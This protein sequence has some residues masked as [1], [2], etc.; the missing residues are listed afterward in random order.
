MSDATPAQM[1][2][3][4]AAE[5]DRQGWQY[6]LD[7]GSALI[8]EIEKRGSVDPKAL[9][10]AV[11]AT[12]LERNR[13]TRENLAAAIARAIGD[14]TPVQRK[15]VATLVIEDHSHNVTISGNAQVHDNNFNVG[16]GTQVNV[17]VGGMRENVVAALAALLSAG[18]G[19]DWNEEAAAGLAQVIQ[20]RDD[21][22]LDDVIKTTA[23]IVKL[24]QPSAS[25]ARE[26]ME[27][28]ATA[29][30]GGAFGTGI[31]AV[32][33]QLIANPPL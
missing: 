13:T 4:L 14:H 10:D 2:S 1:Q 3:L 25:R 20:K 8:A 19:G 27:K 26:M 21:I 22:D 16:D 15:E 17:S 12:F 24:E 28:I 6:D 7:L 29:G 5:L 32:L 33:G 18:F 9:A 11:P 31:T 30:L 23:E